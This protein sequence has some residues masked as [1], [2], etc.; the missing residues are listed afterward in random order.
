MGADELNMDF[1]RRLLRRS[2][3][4]AEQLHDRAYA[5]LVSIG[6]SFF[7]C[8][9]EP[10]TID[11]PDGVTY[12]VPREQLDEFMNANEHDHFYRWAVGCWREDAR[13]ASS[14]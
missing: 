5:H 7:S 3:L 12:R 6:C 1:L 8:A 4:T 10:Y 14:F 2:P 11:A 9:G 13:F